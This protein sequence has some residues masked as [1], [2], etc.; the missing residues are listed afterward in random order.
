MA[1]IDRIIINYFPEKSKQQYATNASVE[2]STESAIS[3]Q[4]TATIQPRDSY[5]DVSS[6]YVEEIIK[7]YLWQSIYHLLQSIPWYFFNIFL[8]GVFLWILVGRIHWRRVLRKSIEQIQKS[9]EDLAKATVRCGYIVYK[10]LP[11]IPLMFLAAIVHGSIIIEEEFGLKE[12]AK[13]VIKRVK[14]ARDYL[15]YNWV[16]DRLHL[17]QQLT[18]NWIGRNKFGI[19][20]AIFFWWLFGEM[21]MRNIEES[22]RPQEEVD[23][24]IP[25][26]YWHHRSL[27]L[28]AFRGQC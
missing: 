3:A 15:R 7:D 25:V 17:Y 16:T 27:H 14:Y 18:V 21:I 4:A 12:K 28:G 10:W 1:N 6:S 2:M 8:P 13:S 23:F 5:T 24:I 26:A 11:L 20:Y 9:S 22:I 19:A